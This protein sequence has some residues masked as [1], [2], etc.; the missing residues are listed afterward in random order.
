MTYNDPRDT[1]LLEEFRKLKSR[2]ERLE[3]TPRAI[4]ASIDTGTFTVVSPDT[5][6]VVALFGQLPSLYNRIDGTPQ[7]GIILYREDGTMAA[8]L[9]D[10]NPLVPPFK[11]SWQVLDR[12]NHVIFADDTNSGVGMALPW[13]PWS[14][15]Q[16]NSP[17]TDTTT[18]GTF[19]TVQTTVGYKINARIQMQ[20]LIRSD[21]VGTT[22][23]VQVVDQ[24]SNV[25]DAIIAVPSASFFYMQLGPTPLAGGYLDPISLFVQA[26]RT[27]GTGTI[28]V[29]GIYVMGLQ[30]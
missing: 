15:F 18:S 11:Q 12:N 9:A 27:A 25:I 1:E 23:E 24:S 16:S 14:G 20:L 10:L 22:G 3:R 19:V 7:S 2:L 8:I 21:S 29:R 13:L 17:P 30:S 5:G 28:G 6:L 4:S 26:R